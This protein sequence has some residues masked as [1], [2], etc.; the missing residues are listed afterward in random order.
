MSWNEIS[1]INTA[2]HDRWPP[3][4]GV[5]KMKYTEKI[6]AQRLLKMLKKKEPCLCCPAQPYFT[7]SGDRCISRR[8][9][10]ATF[11][12]GACEI[13]QKFIGLT[14]GDCPCYRLKGKEAI[15]RTWLA[16]EAKGYI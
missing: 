3:L 13:C 14:I 7:T 5:N 6:H 12:G 10:S 11:G 2:G 1:E 9:L 4:T 15:K 16:L 8:F